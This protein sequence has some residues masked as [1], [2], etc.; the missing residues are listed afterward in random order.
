MVPVGPPTGCCPGCGERTDYV[1]TDCRWSHPSGT[2]G[3]EPGGS[4]AEAYGWVPCE[5]YG[6]GCDRCASRGYMEV[7][8]EREIEAMQAIACGGGRRAA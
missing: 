8:P 3:W 7:L 4:S 1:H 5:C 6:M 2:G